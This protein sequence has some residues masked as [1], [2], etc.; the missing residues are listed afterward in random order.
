VKHILAR[1]TALG[2]QLL[3]FVDD[4]IANGTLD[5]ALEGSRDVAAPGREGVDDAS[6]LAVGEGDGQWAAEEEE[7]E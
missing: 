4:G 7:K 5:V 3:G 1:R 2:G 6:V